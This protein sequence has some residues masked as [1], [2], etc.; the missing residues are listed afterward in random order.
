MSSGDLDDP[1]G[2][3]S[4]KDSLGGAQVPT[5][6]LNPCTPQPPAVGTRGGAEDGVRARAPTSN[7][8]GHRAWPGPQQPRSHLLSLWPR[9][10][11]ILPSRLSSQRPRPEARAPPCSVSTVPGG[12][13]LAGPSFPESRTPGARESH[14]CAEPSA[15]SVDKTRSACGPRGPCRPPGMRTVAW[16]YTL[17]VIVVFLETKWL[18]LKDASCRQMRK[19]GPSHSRGP[20][21]CTHAPAP[22]SWGLSTPS[23]H[24]PMTQGEGR[25]R[26][27]HT[28]TEL[29]GR[30]TSLGGKG[31]HEE[32]PH[33]AWLPPRAGGKLQ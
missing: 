1:A 15:A 33:A 21:P 2:A 28:A 5:S 12:C 32:A 13:H 30:E 10:L 29:R 23:V 9:G 20:F 19:Q 24:L 14:V 4:G 7:P 16:T 25:K 22:G 11:R 6:P 27:G 18:K 3:G 8:K 26:P 17:F 31:L